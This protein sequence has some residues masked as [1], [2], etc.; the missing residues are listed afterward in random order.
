MPTT[1]SITPDAST[2]G[3]TT[4]PSSANQE[5]YWESPGTFITSEA[6]TTVEIWALA[7]TQSTGR[8]GFFRDGLLDIF[9]V[10]Y[11]VI[12]EHLY[13]RT[14]AEGTIATSSLDHAA[15]QIDDLD[16]ATR[17]GWT[18]LFNGPA[19][20]VDDPSLLTTLWG[21]SV[22]IPWAPGQRDLFF[23]LAPSFV[24]GCRTRTT[25]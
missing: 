22:D 9:P 12:A 14:S 1:P 20:R 19:T 17:S 21:K 13:F 16:Q 8:L 6:L 2:T 11:F 4:I 7:T 24:R 3:P 25:H 23:D 18:I 10:N 5:A 15:F